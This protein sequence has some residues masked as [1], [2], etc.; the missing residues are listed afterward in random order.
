MEKT[1]I[2]RISVQ[3]LD[4]KNY[5]VPIIRG[6]PQEI[7]IMAMTVADAIVKN[8]PEMRKCYRRIGW[9][10]YKE[11]RPEWLNTAAVYA[12]GCVVL[13]GAVALVGNG[14]VLIGKAVGLW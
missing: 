2:S 7:L 5:G 1:E 8:H 6:N 12:L 3:M 10:V 13:L 14:M 9:K 11:T 4:G